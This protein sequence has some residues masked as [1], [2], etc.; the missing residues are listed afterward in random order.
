ML[1]DARDRSHGRLTQCGAADPL[2][3]LHEEGLM[4]DLR[5]WAQW[6]RVNA[7][8]DFVRV[9]CGGGGYLFRSK[10]SGLCFV[11][12]LGDN[13]PTPPTRIVGFNFASG[14]SDN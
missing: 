13:P 9:P 4:E 7:T 2:P 8:L 11:P 12:D 1:L 5:D 3:A 14:R 6:E 10:G